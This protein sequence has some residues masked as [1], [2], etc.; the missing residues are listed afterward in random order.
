LNSIKTHQTGSG[1]GI[2]APTAGSIVNYLTTFQT[3]LNTAYTNALT[4][5]ST[6][7][8]VTG[9]LYNATTGAVA[10][11]STY[12]ESTL[13][14]GTR[15]VTFASADQARYFFNAGGSLNFVITST[16]NGDGTARTADCASLFTSLGSVRVY[17]ATNGG[18]TGTGNTATT[19]NT[20]VG[21]FNM[22]YSTPV[23]YFQITTT[24]ATYAGEF[25]KLYMNTGGTK[26][27]NGDNGFQ[28]VFYL[29]LYSAHTSTTSGLYGTSGDTLN[30]TVGHRI[31][32]IPPE[33]TN[34][35]NSWGSITVS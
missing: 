4:S 1:T 17:A 35:S 9:S 27:S 12:G 19:N 23:T 20:A 18:R 21:Y 15:T 24:S 3:S 16:F 13:T 25:M 10:N 30:L 2:S 31:D 33:T 5:A 7:T 34:L 32:I 28:M 11:N 8:T 22:S 14:T 6:G 29:N 26:G